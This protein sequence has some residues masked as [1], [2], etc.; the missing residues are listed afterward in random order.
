MPNLIWKPNERNEPSATSYGDNKS[1]PPF[2]IDDVADISSP[3][4][5]GVYS[6]KVG[7]FA[8]KTGS[9]ELPKTLL[10]RT[11]GDVS[12]P[13]S[14]MNGCG[15]AKIHLDIGVGTTRCE[16]CIPTTSS[17]KKKHPGDN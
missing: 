9:F 8:V 6:L 14:V 5:T 13:V 7:G 15:D 11:S 16:S 4:K 3:W 17:S 12:V 1:K 10:V 2:K